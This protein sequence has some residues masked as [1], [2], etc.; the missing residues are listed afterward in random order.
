MPTLR[1]TAPAIGDPARKALYLATSAPL[2]IDAEGESLLL[3]RTGHAT[4][5]YAVI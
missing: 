1:I 2:R 5:R 3:R 4:A